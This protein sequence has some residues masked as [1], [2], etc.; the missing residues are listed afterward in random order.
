MDRARV[1]NSS[2][3]MIPMG[4]SL[5]IHHKQR[6]LVSWAQAPPLPT[7]SHAQLRKHAPSPPPLRSFCCSL[8]WGRISR[9]H[10]QSFL[11]ATQP[12]KHREFHSLQEKHS[13][14]AS[15]LPSIQGAYLVWAQQG[16]H[17][18]AH[19]ADKF[20]LPGEELVTEISVSSTEGS[21]PP[22][23]NTIHIAV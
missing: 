19:A 5:C 18:K 7:A 16:L 23:P 15:P 17:T 11:P 3:A 1:L 20:T 10:S 6:P 2:L 8:L 9:C 12:L 14:A 21:A 13:A 22:I 4:R